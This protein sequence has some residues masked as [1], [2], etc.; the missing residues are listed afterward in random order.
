MDNWA[1]AYYSICSLGFQ[2][3]GL[4]PSLAFQQHTFPYF[5]GHELRFKS[6]LA[7]KAMTDKQN[8]SQKDKPANSLSLNFERAH[9]EGRYLV[10]R[11]E[12]VLC[13]FRIVV[14]MRTIV[15]ISPAAAKRDKPDDEGQARQ[16]IHLSTTG[17]AEQSAKSSN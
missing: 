8:L 6:I 14:G 16:S 17:G 4:I 9:C 10:Q 13:A 15:A 11:A 5:L 3:N 7:L 12:F 2:I 1:A